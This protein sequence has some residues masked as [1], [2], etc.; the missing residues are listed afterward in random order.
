M[1]FALKSEKLIVGGLFMHLDSMTRRFVTTVGICVCVALV[2]ARSAAQI[3]QLFVEALDASGQPILGLTAED[4]VVSVDDEQVPVESAVFANGPMKIALLVDHGN[5]L[6]EANGTNALRDGLNAFLDTLPPQHEIGLFSIARSINRRV[7]FTDDRDELREGVGLI[8]AESGAPA[9]L[10]DGVNE[11]WERRFDEEDTYPV[12][13]LVLTDNS[14]GSGNWND[15]E[16]SELLYTLV[17][18][19]VTVHTVVV[20]TRGGS[21]VSN[22][23]LNISQFTGGLYLNINAVTGLEDQL[24]DLATRMGE[25]FDQVSNRYRVLF[26]WP[27]DTSVSLGIS[28]QPGAAIRLFP[29]RRIPQ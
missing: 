14:E 1:F 22:T 8:F 24:T 7:D 25:H 15:D 29:D 12:F 27:P 20:M 5:Q 6:N 21:N 18:S 28:S 4:M 17:G 23:A 10:L 2:P 13:V 26:N 19:G 9:V 3:G 16:Y 11:T